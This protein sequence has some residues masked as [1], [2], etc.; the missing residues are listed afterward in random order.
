M[1]SKFLIPR[2][3][4]LIAAYTLV[5][6]LPVSF[7]FFSQLK[8][9][10]FRHPLEPSE[11]YPTFNTAMA[12]L[13]FFL[14][15]SI[16]LLL[17]AWLYYHFNYQKRITQYSDANLFNKKFLKKIDNSSGQLSRAQ[18]TDPL[19]GG[20]C[21]QIGTYILGLGLFLL[22][23]V[24]GFF[25]AFFIKNFAWQ[26]AGLIFF[27]ALFLSFIIASK[28]F[29]D[30]IMKIFF[31]IF[32]GLMVAYLF[33]HAGLGSNRSISTFDQ[34]NTGYFGIGLLYALIIASVLFTC[35]LLYKFFK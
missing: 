21:T 9:T 15:C 2:A 26:L 1:I 5:Q 34:W 19:W 23:I 11:A 10:T 28:F 12:Y 18:L 16:P 24:F 32:M 20:D 4:L 30:K 27:S 6:A 14:T 22:A 25:L 3:T 13:A 17:M 33:L 31:I 29:T 8:D 35:Y 7:F